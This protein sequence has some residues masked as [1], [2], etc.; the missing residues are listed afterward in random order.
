MSE[1]IF[2]RDCS[3]SNKLYLYQ[4]ILIQYY[5]ELA[6]RGDT[7]E[8]IGTQNRREIRRSC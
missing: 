6:L 4:L 3:K 5:G 1:L 7:G 8:A 2:M